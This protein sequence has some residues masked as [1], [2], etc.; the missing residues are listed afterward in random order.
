MEEF[1]ASTK[2]KAVSKQHSPAPTDASSASGIDS[3]GSTTDAVT[4][5]TST[6]VMTEGGDQRRA[7]EAIAAADSARVVA[8]AAAVVWAQALSAVTRLIHTA[9]ASLCEHVSDALS[10]EHDELHRLT[11]PLSSVED[12]FGIDELHSQGT[13]DVIPW[14]CKEAKPRSMMA[15]RAL[16]QYVDSGAEQIRRAVAERAV[17]TVIPPSPIVASVGSQTENIAVQVK[18]YTEEGHE[19][20]A[21]RQGT[22]VGVQ[23]DRPVVGDD[24]VGEGSPGEH[25]GAPAWEGR[26]ALHKHK[27][28]SDSQDD[29]HRQRQAMEIEHAAA[30]VQNLR[31]EADALGKALTHAEDEKR[32]LKRSL[33]RRFE[34]E[35]VRDQT[36]ARCVA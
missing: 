34:R 31:R 30:V 16:G 33:T 32:S 20:Y 8:E 11:V 21:P 13:N 3:G 23:V 4:F 28:H 25:G 35:K 26:K 22:S 27:G 9:L 10:A 2:G 6:A 15:L 1:V 29:Q 18:A 19:G 5:A 17:R 12:L 24:R 14:A 36:K 7:V